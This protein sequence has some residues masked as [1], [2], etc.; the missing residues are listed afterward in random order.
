MQKQ[1]G[2]GSGEE[3]MDLREIT[4]C[5]KKEVRGSDRAGQGVTA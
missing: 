5:T 4:H 3:R 1:G 2:P